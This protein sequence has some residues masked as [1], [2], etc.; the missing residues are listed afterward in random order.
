MKTGRYRE[1]ARGEH[2]RTGRTLAPN[3]ART[4]GPDEKRYLVWGILRLT[5]GV[6][7]I[8]FSAT[9]FLCLIFVGLWSSA[10]LTCVTVATIATLAS[11]ALFHGQSGTL[12]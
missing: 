9:A 7:Q 8:S 1:Q 6:L 2:H 4:I 5:L 11:R 3:S 12:R 10:T